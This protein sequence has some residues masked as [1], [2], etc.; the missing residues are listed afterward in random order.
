MA[1]TTSSLIVMMLLMMLLCVA[2][3]Y[4]QHLATQAV[5]VQIRTH[6]EP[7][8][9]KVCFINSQTSK[10]AHLSCRVVSCHV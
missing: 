9:A 4:G 2:H 6:I 3:I 5:P 7:I 10:D 8:V 1:S